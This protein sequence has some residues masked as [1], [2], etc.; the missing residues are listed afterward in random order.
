MPP[1][2]SLTGAHLQ[3]AFLH[4]QTVRSRVKAVVKSAVMRKAPAASETMLKQS[5]D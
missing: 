3:A 1:V 5:Q 2:Q 4:R